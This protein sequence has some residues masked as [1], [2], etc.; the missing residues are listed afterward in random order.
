[1][2]GSIELIRFIV[3]IVAGIAFTALCLILIFSKPSPKTA[4]GKPQKK[5]PAAPKKREDSPVARTE[6]K[7]EK[8]PVVYE[9]HVHYDSVVDDKGNTVSVPDSN[10]DAES[11][12]GLYDVTPDADSITREK[13]LMLNSLG[14][15]TDEANI[16]SHVRR[17]IECG[18]LKG[19][20][21]KVIE[22]ILS[23]K[24]GGTEVPVPSPEIDSFG[25]PV[26][27]EE[28]P[29]AYPDQPSPTE[30]EE[31]IEMPQDEMGI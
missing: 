4:K 8:T 2:N 11:I 14:D 23:A 25:E 13:V 18:L 28:Y 21:N 29:A 5:T 3:E 31:R 9:I 6:K 12:E 20:P 22:E 7:K 27:E 24:D 26:E 30:M 17:L 19:D 16:E 10:S 15:E 1:M